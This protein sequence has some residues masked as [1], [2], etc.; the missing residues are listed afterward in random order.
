MPEHKFS[1]TRSLKGISHSF[2]VLRLLPVQTGISVPWITVTLILRIGKN[3]KCR[4][5]ISS[6]TEEF[7]LRVWGPSIKTITVANKACST[8]IK[9]SLFTSSQ[10]LFLKSTS[11]SHMTE[12]LFLRI[13]RWNK[14][15]SKCL[16]V[17]LLRVNFRVNITL[18]VWVRQTESRTI[19]GPRALIL[20]RRWPWWAKTVK[21][22]KVTANKPPL[23]SN[24]QKAKSSSRSRWKICKII[25]LFHSKINTTRAPSTTIAW[26]YP[27][28]SWTIS[29]NKSTL[30][31]KTRANKNL[32]LNLKR[33]RKIIFRQSPGM[34]V[35]QL[36]KAPATSP[37]ALPSESIKRTKKLR[38]IQLKLRSTCFRVW[39]RVPIPRDCKKMKLV[40][41]CR[42]IMRRMIKLL[43]ILMTSSLL[44]TRPMISFSNSCLRR[45]SS[46]SRRSYFCSRSKT[47]TLLLQRM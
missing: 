20:T 26:N 24:N 35:K 32:R 37:R 25:S 28:L 36:Y 38:E 6:N 33:S 18:L 9:I 45:I 12:S 40:R 27:V 21:W 22:T 2:R 8:I 15:V 7:Y 17:K 43:L 34:I 44:A 39:I 29:I 47:K 30:W 19:W 23:S 3:Y 31:W 42:K 4:G 14:V 1:V 11:I 10:Q 46:F 41:W 5:S 16:P 13:R